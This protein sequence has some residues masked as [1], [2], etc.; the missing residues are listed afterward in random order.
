MR[1]RSQASLP[2]L[3]VRGGRGEGKFKMGTLKEDMAE[4]LDT[5]LNDDEFADEFVFSRSGVTINCIFDDAFAV[6]IE[7]EQGV[8][9]S[10]P[11]A[12]A[13]DS[14]V[15]GIVQGDTLTRVSTSIVYNVIKP[16]PDG[17]GMT[18]VLLSQN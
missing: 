11:Q 16:M 3:L 5:F 15:T 1:E 6:G 18:V 8:E 14:D 13:K 4:D 7:G 17:T 9:T 12:V 2:S 10:E